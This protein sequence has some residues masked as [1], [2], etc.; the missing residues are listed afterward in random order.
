MTHKGAALESM[1]ACLKPGGR[2]LV[3]EFSK[4]VSP[5]LKTLYDTWSFNVIPRLGKVITADRESYEYLVESIRVHP[6][7]EELKQMMRSAGFDEVHYN[8][9]SGG[10][11]AVH[12]GHKY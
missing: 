1:Y 11:V 2:L 6:G 12:I 8:N 5:L 9:L 4:P 10:I 3:L 7:Q